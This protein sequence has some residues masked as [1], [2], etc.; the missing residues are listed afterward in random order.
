MLSTMVVKTSMIISQILPYLSL[1]STSASATAYAYS[2]IP[3]ME[4]WGSKTELIYFTKMPWATSP[5]LNQ[6]ME[7]SGFSEFLS[8]YHF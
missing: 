5:D 2:A 8:N 1:A 3:E 6:W 7:Y 4:C